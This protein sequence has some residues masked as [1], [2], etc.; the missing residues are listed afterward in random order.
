MEGKDHRLVAREQRVEIPVLQSVRVLGLRLQ[1]HE[2][3]HV[4]DADPNVR[5]VVS[6]Q[7]HGCESFERRN[8]T[9]AGHD[10]IGIVRIVARPLPDAGA[11]RAVAN[12]GFDIEPLPL[13]LFAGND[14]VDVVPA[15]KT[16]IGDREQ[17]V[18]VGRQIDA[19]D[20][21][22]LARD[23][24]DEARILMGEAVVILPPDMRREQIIQRR[25]RLAPRD[26]FGRLQ[27]FRMLIEHRVDDVDERL[28]AREKA[29]TAGEQVAFEPALAEVL[30]QDLH[31]AAVDAEIDVDI[32][33]ARHPLL[34]A[35][36]VDRVETVRGGLIRT[37]QAEILVGEVQLHH[38]AQKRPEH[39][40]RLRPRRC[41]AL[42]PRT[43]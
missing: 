36:L 42:K 22:L 19:H 30:A 11:D 20:V 41:P 25:D 34:A 5:N 9:R 10:H 33:D 8:I 29:V 27:P 3:D 1:S 43:A 21:G 12:G 18:R 17:A 13:G 32:L 7:G 31:D 28:V 38:V 6:Q 2:V 23:V 4:H 40:R 15:A 37:E 26:C 24:I 39:A 14:Q 35:D 16:V